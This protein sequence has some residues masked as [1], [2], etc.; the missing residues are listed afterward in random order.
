MTSAGDDKDS[1][2]ETYY[3]EI[4]TSLIIAGL[5]INISILVRIKYGVEVIT[6]FT[7]KPYT[8]TLFLLILMLAQEICDQITVIHTG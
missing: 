4:N 2:S 6:H 3:S 7:Y 8:V 5:L 1:S